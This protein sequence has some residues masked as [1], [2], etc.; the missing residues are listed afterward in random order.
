MFPEPLNTINAAYHEARKTYEALE[1]RSRYERIDRA[2]LRYQ[3]R[4]LAV[5]GDLRLRRL[6]AP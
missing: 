1:Y 2:E 5:L 6:M 4:I 3:G